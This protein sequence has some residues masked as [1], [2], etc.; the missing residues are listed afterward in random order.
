M[1]RT[2]RIALVLLV[3]LMCSSI[4]ALLGRS[5]FAQTEPRRGPTAPTRVTN[6]PPP[7]P[8]GTSAPGLPVGTGLTP[9]NTSLL[10]PP[11][12]TVQHYLP[13]YNARLTR[14]VPKLSEALKALSGKRHTMAANGETI[15]LTGDLNFLY[16]NDQTLPYDAD[17]FYLCQNM[18]PNKNYRYV[19]FPPNS[20][21]ITPGVQGGI[22]AGGTIFASNAAG[23]CISNTNTNYAQV[24]LS[25]PVGVGTDPAY[26]GVWAVGVQQGTCS[27]P[28]TTCATF[29][30]GAF[31]TVAYTVVISTLH[32]DT[33]SDALFTVPEKDYQPGQT[34]YFSANGLTSGHQ[35]AFG[36]VYT[37]GN[38]TPCVFTLPGAAQNSN[39][40]SCFHGG[41]GAVP[42]G[43]LPFSGVVQG[44]W[45][46]P[47]VPNTG[48]YS[49]QLYDVTTQDLVSTSQ[50][51]IQP[52]SVTIGLI[53]FG[54]A[55]ANTGPNVAD[56]FAT[57]GIINSGGAVNVEQSV[58]GVN[59]TANSLTVGHAYSLVLT[60]PN[61]VVLTQTTLDTQDF[62][63]PQS[64]NA[65]TTTQTVAFS[66]PS[67]KALFSGIG[68][69]L[70]SFAPNVMTLQ[71]FDKTAQTVLGSKSMHIL[72]YTAGLQWT[73]PAASSVT[74][75][76]TATAE[77]V[78][79][80]NTAGQNYGEWNGDGIKQVILS[81]DAAAQMTLTLNGTTATDS[82]GQTWTVSTAAGTIIATPNVAG[83]F[84]KVDSTLNI[85]LN[86]AVPVNGNCKTAFCTLRTQIVPFHGITASAFD[87]A[88]N[89]LQVFGVGGVPAT[90]SPTYQWVA[91]AGP[92]GLGTPRFPQMLYEHGTQTVVTGSY[93]MTMNIVNCGTAQNLQEIKFSMPA[94][95]DANTAGQ[96]PTLNTLT[97]NG[98]NVKANWRLYTA[99]TGGQRGLALSQNEFALG[100]VLP[101]TG[102]TVN[103]CGLPKP[104]AACTPTAAQTMVV[105]LLWPIPLLT[106]QPTKIAATANY[107][108]GCVSSACAMTTFPV[109]AVQQLIDPV[110]NVPSNIDS[111]ELAFYSLD[112]S[113]MTAVWSPATVPQGIATTSNF[114]FTNTPTAADPNPDYVDEITIFVPTAA[115][116]TSITP[117]TNWTQNSAVVGGGG[118]TFTFS[119]CPGGVPPCGASL[120]TNPGAQEPN[121]LAPG[122][123][124]NFQ[125]NWTVA[126]LPAAAT[127]ATTWTAFGANGG[128][129]TAT[130]T[131]SILF[132]NT[133]AQVSFA[134]AGAGDG[135]SG[136]VLPDVVSPGQ[137]ATVGSDFDPVYGNGYVIQLLNNGTQTI[138]SATINIPVADVLAAKPTDTAHDWQVSSAFVYPGNGGA[139]CNGAVAA[140]NLVKPVVATTTAG[141]IKLT[142]CTLAPNATMKIFFL[143]AAP[144]D[145]PN[146]FY[147]FNGTVTS[148]VTANAPTQ[149]AYTNSD[150]LLVVSDA[151]LRIFIPIAANT[152]NL[153]DAGA[154]Q[155]PVTCVG[156]AY[157]AATSTIDFGSI[158]GTFN[159]KDIVN[160]VVNSDTQGSHGWQL[161]VQ[162]TSAPPTG[163]TFT[164]SVDNTA[165]F[166]SASAFYTNNQSTLITPSAIAPGTLLSTF[167]SATAASTFTHTPIQN[168]MN[169]TV[170]LPAF[171]TAL[172]PGANSVT[173]T[174]TLIPN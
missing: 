12:K 162:L 131:T 133:T 8:M 127:Y 65:A 13:A 159:A 108:G 43:V 164:T 5:A 64:F 7:L 173:L 51:S 111:T 6:T 137:Q 170:T 98:V 143:S 73:A 29:T 117:P 52:A 129:H 94:Q 18:T 34:L 104:N 20:A 36:V 151:R 101:G 58:S 63:A 23:N 88:T 93:A 152:I 25:T 68:P 165:G 59:V 86:V 122:D 40:T 168:F 142:G 95:F 147:R 74:V 83:Q 158:A 16:L 109:G 156:C 44:S 113:L 118:T 35:Y 97:I 139:G 45:T 21:P 112:G 30:P 114:Q 81:P 120:P 22:G 126:N 62:N 160:A 107:Q 167:A 102:N 37:G 140:A 149:T 10:P 119:V 161:F 87:I 82:D 141:S 50:V 89:G 154:T 9:F 85:P 138:T 103:G 153:G 75:A 121:A 169:A 19:I 76:T 70:T 136:G 130:L 24:N 116:P 124:I 38:N 92:G 106:F 28:V 84:L 48:T 26:P 39:N 91:G 157:T 155:K 71:I 41:A 3:A 79:V 55:P 132:A 150:T 96:A 61:G 33:Y 100:C 56:T 145:Q 99:A 163:G 31:Q 146:H 148:A 72:A 17:V 1:S 77:T 53:P 135:T 42:T 54:T 66:W 49:V 110:P 2:T 128:A 32:F 69:T 166:Q 171:P 172:T 78:Q 14:P 115:K 80:T 11:I 15:V 47:A 125:F 57:D 90:G 4:L 174:Y 67:I 46:I 60:T 134:N 144:Y 105:G 123:T 27:A